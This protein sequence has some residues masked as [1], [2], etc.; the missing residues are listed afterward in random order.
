[1]FLTIILAI[2]VNAQQLN[3]VYIL[4]EGGFNAGTSM[5]SKL[6]LPGSDFT[7]SIFGPGNIGLYPDGLFVDDQNIYVVE[8]GNFGGPGKIYKLEKD[9]TVINAQEIGTNPYSLTISNK[10]VYV[11]NGPA[12][13][14]TVVNKSDF[15]IV[16]DIMVGV[17][18]QEIISFQGHV[19]VANNGLW[20]GDSDSTITVISSE[21]D[22]VVS[23]ITVRKD[24]SSLAISNDGNLLIGC[25]NGTIYEVEL[26]TFAKVDSLEIPEFGFGKDINIDKNS[27]TIYFKSSTN[28]IVGLDLLTREVKS[29]VS[30][31]TVLFTYG[32]G[33]DYLSGNHYLTDAKDFAANGSL[34]VYNSEGSLLK[35]YETSTAPRRIAF[36]YS[37]NTVLV[38]N[39]NFESKFS[40]EQ[41]YPNP[42]NPVTTINYS[43]PKV[44]DENIQS[45]R[46]KVYDG[47]G[48][49]IKTLVNKQHA[50]GNYSVHFDA[51]Q[52][53]SGVYYYRMKYDEFIETKKMIILK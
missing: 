47:L 26:T 30:D 29:A 44:G 4:S 3:R 50:P 45:V 32:Y 21:T 49:E 13:S 6:S 9:G 28:Q 35:T 24:P 37:Q 12:S 39:E 33:Y 19:F 41:N 48:N 53:T 7:Q 34:N 10:K 5:L 17:Y 46:I 43:I 16:K 2:V 52:L 22:E 20:G 11:T 18:P 8:Q 27:D 14:V 23:I 40:L 25:T 31:P 36:D 1:M 15:S 42:F 51:S 38:N